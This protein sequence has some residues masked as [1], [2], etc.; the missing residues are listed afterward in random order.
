M[1]STVVPFLM[2]AGLVLGICYLKQ[3]KQKID[4]L[5]TTIKKSG[6]KIAEEFKGNNCGCDCNQ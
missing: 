4:H 6:N 2:G 1:K 3:N 5:M